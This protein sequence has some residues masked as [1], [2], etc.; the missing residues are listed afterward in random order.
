MTGKNDNDYAL[1]MDVYYKDGTTRYGVTTQFSIGTHDWQKRTSVFKPDKPIAYV[2]FYALF[3]NNHTGKIWW[4]DLSVREVSENGVKYED[5]VVQALPIPQQTTFTTINTNDGLELSLGEHGVTSL[6]VLGS[7]VAD[8]TAP[9]GFLVMDEAAG[10]DVYYFDRSANSNPLNYHGTIEELGLEINA[11]FSVVNGAIKVNGKLSNKLATD[12]AVTLTFALPVNAAGW[13]WGDDIRSSRTI[14]VGGYNNIYS[15]T[16]ANIPDSGPVSIY[17]ISA[18]Y[19]E[20][21]NQGLSIGTDFNKPAHYRLDYNGGTKQLLITYELGLTTDTLKFPNS[22]DFGFVI[23]P[24]DANWGFRSAF[25]KYANL[26]PD[27]FETRIKD[28]GIW[29][30]FAPISEV[31]NWQ[32]FGFKVKGGETERQFNAENGIMHFEY[33][34]LASWWQKID[35][36]MP[37]TL[38]TAIA[39]R[40]QAVA[41][42]KPPISRD[43]YQNVHQMAVMSQNSA[44]LN[45]NGDP[46]LTWESKPWNTGAR[47][48]INANP[49]LPG[50]PNGYNFYYNDAIFQDLYYGAYP[51]AGELLDSLDARSNQLNFNRS[52]FAYANTPLTYSKISY[53]PAIHGAFSTLEAVMRISDKMRSMNKYTMANATP[54]FYSMYMPWLDTGGIEMNWLGGDGS[55]VPVPDKTLSMYRTISYQKPYGI[56]QNTDFNLFTN[57]Y[58][59]KYMQRTMFYGI[60]PSAFS[61]DAFNGI[62]W[63]NPS[64]YERDRALFK[65]YIPIIKQMAESGWEPITHAASSN[66]NIYVERYGHGSSV[67]VTLMNDAKTAQTATISINPAMMGLN[68]NTFTAKELVSDSYITVAGNQFTVTLDPDQTYAIQLVEADITPPVTQASLYPAS[69]NGDNGWHTSDVTVILA[70][71]DSQSD[72]A[73]TVYCMNGGECTNYTG[74]L[75]V[76]TEGTTTVEYRSTDRA[77]NREEVQSFVLNIDKTAPTLSVQVDKPVL[78]PPNHKLVPVTVTYAVYDYASSIASVVLTS[79]TSSEPDNGLGDGDTE[80]D[81]QDVELGTLDTA[82]QLR[83]ERSGNG[84][85]RVYTITYTAT[86]VAGNKTTATANVTVPVNNRDKP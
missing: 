77:G 67:Y 64:M 82:F 38:E 23:Y 73:K 44:M 41:N 61:N 70:S 13:Q 75:V 74:N 17:P 28:Q 55:Y 54:L 80:N 84:V 8:P 62:Y 51:V 31:A 53:R 40:D 36:S 57:S 86:D 21:S 52:H 4:D 33:S 2:N 14:Q 19:N 63:K 26:F 16:S 65:T 6:K 5:T 50:E 76:D 72:I 71:T 42:P 15:V 49:D 47:W 78:W 79:I 58:M 34:E 10:S 85:G 39:M 25:E 45:E 48:F 66:P 59:D 22:A 32:D 43:Q 24:F 37:K 83:A 3:R 11:D 46:Y 68:G 29:M 7:E 81:I 12:R 69:P 60:F 35:P 1:Y 56:L 27:M 18:I 20:Q 30:P 9:S